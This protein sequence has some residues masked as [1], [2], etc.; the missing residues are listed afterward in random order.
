[1]RKMK[2]LLV[3]DHA[4]FR[5]VFRK[6]LQTSVLVEEILEAENGDTAIVMTRDHQPDLIFMDL[7]MPKD[8]LS[9]T[10][11]IHQGWPDIKIVILTVHAKK[12]FVEKAIEF[13]A[14]G[15]LIKKSVKQE[16]IEAFNSIKKG[17]LY[18]SR[19]LN[20]WKEEG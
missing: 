3:D 14:S 8:G 9:A 12:S 6:I 16:L 11:T 10:K 4:P 20:N 5:E 1:M 18:I 19:E 15:Y 17:E 13:G 7:A 2:I